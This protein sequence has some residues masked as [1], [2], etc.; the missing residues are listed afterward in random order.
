MLAPSSVKQERL[1]WYHAEREAIAAVLCEI[2]G[3]SPDHSKQTCQ[4]MRERTYAAVETTNPQQQHALAAA[5]DRFTRLGIR[6]LDYVEGID[7]NWV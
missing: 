6:T 1:A 2:G 7:P 3:L 4:L 5:L